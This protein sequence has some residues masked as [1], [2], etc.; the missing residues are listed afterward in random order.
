[1][2]TKM[3]NLKC[4]VLFVLAILNGSALF[5]QTVDEAKKH[6][7]YEK[8]ISAK[9]TLE[10]V[11]KANPN[12]VDA[13]YWLGQTYLRDEDN[14]DVAA[15]RKLYQEKLL[16]SNNN[17]LLL[18]GMGHVELFEG[19][20][21]DARQRFE[22]AIGVSQG[23]NVEVLNAIGFANGDFDVKQG[24]PVY[25][26]E[27][28]KQATALKAGA[29]NADVWCNLGDAYRK[30]RDG[31]S[32]QESYSKALEVDP[33]YARANYRAG[34]IYQTQG[35]AD[36]FMPYFEK[37]LAQ[38]PNYTPNIFN[39]QSYYYDINID[40]SA[41]YLDKYLA[42]KGIDEPNGCYYRAAIKLAQKLHKEA[43]AEADACLNSGSKDIRL[44]G[45]KALQYDK[46]GDSVN[47]RAS[48]EK[49]FSLQK[50]EKLGP[51]DY[52]LY[53]NTLLKFADGEAKAVELANNLDG[54][55]DEAT[56]VEI[57][58]NLATRFENAK[59]WKQAG[60]WYAK[61]A[62][63]KKVASNRDFYLAGQYNYQGGE[64]NKALDY[65]GRYAKKYPTDILPFRKLGQVSWAIDS[66]MS[67]AAANPYYN[68]T[69]EIGE[70][71]ADKSKVKTHLLDAYKYYVSYHL[72]ITKSKDSALA[73]CDRALLIEPTNADFL[74]RKASI[75]TLNLN[76]PRANNVAQVPANT[77]M[78]N[79]TTGAAGV[80]AGSGASGG[81]AKPT[82][83]T[84]VK[85]TA[86]KT[87]TSGQKKNR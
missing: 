58:K 37:A 41:L 48:F 24:D 42:A 35:Q 43:I 68:R 18:A 50:K 16:S 62:D 33:K 31:G 83:S 86:V 82:T 49:Y 81:A 54:F 3:K 11:L 4:S 46:L 23:K 67:A 21:T 19:K 70:A 53:I 40:K 30:N 80:A 2:K 78:G 69:I 72:A 32:A 47:T 39:L 52:S 77:A 26:I 34:K 59:N 63:T 9:N 27:K 64:L 75:P 60:Y 5:A 36:I 51:K 6:L 25:A 61:I 29:K 84:A 57:Y 28:L 45:I 13:A 1:M 15:A 73:Y 66:T 8:F 17:P 10:Q 55:D 71:E 65:F 7:Y 22:T 79:T 56:K 20:T 14:R 38:D 87:A 85:A 74:S 76:A 12:D 44:H